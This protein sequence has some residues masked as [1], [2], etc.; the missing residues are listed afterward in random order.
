MAVKNPKIEIGCYYCYQANRQQAESYR[1]HTLMVFS[2]MVHQFGGSYIGKCTDGRTDGCTTCM[3]MS[4]MN[5]A[6]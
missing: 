6:K 4:K 1:V 2:V 3:M 5:N